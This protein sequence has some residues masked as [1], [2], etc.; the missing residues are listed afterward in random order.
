MNHYAVQVLLIDLESK[1]QNYS[2]QL[3][4]NKHLTNRAYTVNF[5]M[6]KLTTVL[7]LELQTVRTEIDYVSYIMHSLELLL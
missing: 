5:R 7:S 1:G 2:L 6:Y 3:Y 4:A